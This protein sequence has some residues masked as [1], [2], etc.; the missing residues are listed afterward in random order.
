MGELM[1]LTT[2]RMKDI[3]VDF[4][5]KADTHSS[6]SVFKQEFDEWLASESP[7]IHAEY[8]KL[9]GEMVWHR[10]WAG[11]ELNLDPVTLKNM[12][13]TQISQAVVDRYRAEHVPEKRN[14]VVAKW[15]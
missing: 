10:Y 15:H 14:I 5:M 6:I 11:R 2:Q 12:S 9:L 1:K 3:Y 4:R 13:I 8:H 7:R